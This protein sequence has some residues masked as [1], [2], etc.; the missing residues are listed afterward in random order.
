MVLELVGDTTQEVGRLGSAVRGIGSVLDPLSF[1]WQDGITS[2]FNRQ[3]V[4]P[5]A[6]FQL[7]WAGYDGFLTVDGESAATLTD[8]TAWT[9]GGGVTPLPGLGL[10]VRYQSSVATTLD[11]RSDRRAYSR[12]WPDVQARIQD[13]TV[14]TFLRRVVTGL[15]LTSGFRRTIREAT[16]GGS[17]LQRRVREDREVPLDLSVRWA[18]AVSTT[19]RGSY[20]DGEGED[21][22]GDT[23]RRRRSHLLS[24]TSSFSPPE[25]FAERLQEPIQLTFGYQYTS[26]TD[27]RA[28]AGRESCTAFMDQIIQSLNLTLD[29]VVSSLQVG[30]QLSYTDRQSFV[31]RRNGS[32]QFQLGFFGQ[33]LFENGEFTGF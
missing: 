9:A 28:T 3:V 26:Q 14:P 25:K 32:T 30:L 27:C 10:S 21:P 24:L 20:V 17:G 11:T 19:Y 29:T 18:G 12:S 31:G 4:D 1:T 8:R 2:R 15:S 6:G 22:T 33:F 23:E 16:Y 7:G 13:I 5:G